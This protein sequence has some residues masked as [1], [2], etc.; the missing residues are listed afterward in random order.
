MQG[1]TY[2]ILKPFGVQEGEKIVQVCIEM[3]TAKDVIEEKKYSNFSDAHA[4]D[5]I[6]VYPN[7]YPRYW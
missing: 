3:M 4:H 2:A 1:N 5:R 6:Q 7:G